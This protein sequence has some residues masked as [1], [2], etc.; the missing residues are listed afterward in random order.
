MPGRLAGRRLYVDLRRVIGA[1]SLD[2]GYCYDCHAGPQLHLP[3]HLDDF[4][5]GSIAQ[6]KGNAGRAAGPVGNQRRFDPVGAT[7]VG[8]LDHLDV[9]D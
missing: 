8:R 3:G 2:L 4:A 9:A 5:R 1:R 7:L 6:P